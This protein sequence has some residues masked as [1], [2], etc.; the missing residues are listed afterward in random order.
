MYVNEL[1]FTNGFRNKLSD[2]LDCS[3]QHKDNNNVM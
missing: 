3:K 1:T 2:L